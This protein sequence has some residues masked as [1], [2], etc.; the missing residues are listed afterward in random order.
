MFFV[1]YTQFAGS[2]KELSPSKMGSLPQVNSIT[3]GCFES[4]RKRIPGVERSSSRGS[5]LLIFSLL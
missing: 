5:D 1:N 4:S 3:T 2:S